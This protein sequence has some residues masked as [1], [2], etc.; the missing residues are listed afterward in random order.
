MEVFKAL[1][2][3]LAEGSDYTAVVAEISAKAGIVLIMSDVEG[4]FTA[5]PKIVKGAKPIP[6][7]SYDEALIASKFGMRA[8]QWKAVKL[9]FGRTKGW[10]MGTLVS[11][12][13]S[14]MP[15]ITYRLEDTHGVVGVMN[16]YPEVPYERISMGENW[17]AFRVPKEETK[18]IIGRTHKGIMREYPP[19][20]EVGMAWA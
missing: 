11:G 9:T 17:V 4:I 1:E 18:R 3:L 13:S 2:Q 20:A 16:A 8:I 19:F 12:K 15:I 14:G 7:V 5:D 6:F 10:Y